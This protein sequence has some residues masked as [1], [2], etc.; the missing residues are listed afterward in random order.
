MASTASL[1][2]PSFEDQQQEI[3]ILADH[4][5]LPRSSRSSIALLLGKLARPFEGAMRYDKTQKK[6]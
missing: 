3:E 5:G 1:L 6:S 4:P 2:L